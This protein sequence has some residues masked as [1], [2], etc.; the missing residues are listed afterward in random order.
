MLSRVFLVTFLALN[1]NDTDSRMSGNRSCESFVGDPQFP[2]IVRRSCS[3]FVVT[4]R[5]CAD[6]NS[7][8][9]LL[10]ALPLDYVLA[11]RAKIGVSNANIFSRLFSL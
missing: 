11:E 9:L 8:C 6:T 10:S 3:S 7:C 1:P 4:C 2:R 5:H